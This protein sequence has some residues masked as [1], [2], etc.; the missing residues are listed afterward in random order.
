MRQL[1]LSSFSRLA[2]VVLAA[3]LVLAAPA[4]SSSPLAA[5]TPDPAAV[6]QLVSLPFGILDHRMGL[7]LGLG[8]I[9]GEGFAFRSMA[10]DPEAIRRAHARA[11]RQ[12]N[13][14]G[15][16]YRLGLLLRADRRPQEAAEALS[17]AVRLALAAAERRPDDPQAAELLA[18]AQLASGDPAAAAVTLRTAVERWP[19]RRST[20]IALGLSLSIAGTPESLH[21]AERVFDAAVAL[22]PRNPDVYAARANFRFGRAREREALD[23]YHR[24]GELGRDDPYALAL[25]PWMEG[26]AAAPVT[27]GQLALDTTWAALSPSAREAI[28][29]TTE[30]LQRLCRHS[31]STVAGK[32]LTALGFVRYEL[33]HDVTGS[34]SALRAALRRDPSRQDAREMILHIYGV[35]EQWDELA[36]CSEA[37][38]RGKDS[39]RLRLIAAFAYSQAG[40][41]AEAASRLDEALRAEPNDLALLL[42]RAALALKHP[43]DPGGDAL[44][45]SL[46]DKAAGLV[47]AQ[48]EFRPEVAYFRGLHLALSGQ[49]EAA[50]AALTEALSSPEASGARQ[51]LA[52]LAYCVSRIP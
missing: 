3:G 27:G 28:S 11:D 30:R 42:T 24:A 40:R 45:G 34:L 38:S 49:S 14:A 6:R 23:D 41:C 52:L 25:A 44:A 4:A 18:R 31:D 46:L 8:Y 50:R 35:E 36:A 13:D 51:A 29:R 43:Q 21:E 39:V 19:G 15:S 9:A 17:H 48:P 37:W 26:A 32:A 16:W 20:R 47:D 22:A 2:C 10:V 12:R 7:T 33:Q 1:C 5:N